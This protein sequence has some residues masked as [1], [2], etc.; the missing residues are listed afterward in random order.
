MSP[1]QPKGVAPGGVAPGFSLPDDAGSKAALADFRGRPVVLYFYPKDDTEG[2]TKEACDF[3]DHW[4]EFQS[5]GAVILGVSPDSVESH[6]KFKAKYD[7]P[8]ALL[9]DADHTVALAYGAWGPKKM[10]GREYEGILRTTVVIDPEGR[11]ARVFPKVKV[12]D[13]ADDVLGALKEMR[14]GE[15]EQ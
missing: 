10:Y 13:H 3:R 7:L 5:A 12:K 6:R 4:R 2:C 15:R 8:F 9:S 14:V 1:T 11:I